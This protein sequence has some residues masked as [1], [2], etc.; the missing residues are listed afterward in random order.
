LSARNEEAFD[1]VADQAGTV[2]TT[3]PATSDPKGLER[4]TYARV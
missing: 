1:E 3:A 2:A 4:S